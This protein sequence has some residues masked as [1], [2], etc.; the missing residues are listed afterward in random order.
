M[1]RYRADI[2]DLDDS[3][4]EQA[5]AQDRRAARA[6]EAERLRRMDEAQ[7]EADSRQRAAAA[8][9]QAQINR[10]QVEQSY[11]AAGLEP[12]LLEPGQI[13]VSLSL[14]LLLGW[15]IHEIGGVKRLVAPKGEP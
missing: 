9:R 13:R 1:T 6:E 4:F 12:P 8:E 11:R 2:D 14:L 3:L 7:A 5:E 15:E 10:A